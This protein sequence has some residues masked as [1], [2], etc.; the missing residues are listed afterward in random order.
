[1]VSRKLDNIKTIDITKGELYPILAALN[2]GV[3]I[4][5]AAG[6]I[7]FY[8]PVHAEMDGLSSHG[9]IG[10]KV[11]E[12]YDLDENSSLVMRCLRTGRPIVECPVIYKTHRG[13]IVDSINNVYPL[14]KQGKV[15]GVISF[16]KDYNR[17]EDPAD[18]GDGKTFRHIFSGDTDFSLDDIIGSNVSLLEAVTRARMAA[19]TDS[20]VLIYGE[21][22]TGKELFAQAIHNLSARKNARYI[23]VNCAAIP[24]TLLEGILFG[25]SKGA[26]TG[27]LDKPGLFERANGGTLFLDEIN[28]MSREMQPKLLRAIQEK[29]VCRIG[30]HRESK[31]ELKII[32]ST[33]TTPEQAMEAGK[34]RRD[35]LYRLSVV[36]ISLP[37]LRSRRDDVPLLTKHFIEKYNALFHKRVAGVSRKVKRIFDEY[38]WPGNVRELENVIE[39]ALNMVGQDKLIET[40]HLTSGFCLLDIES[41]AIYK[42]SVRLKRKHAAIPIGVDA[43]DRSLSSLILPEGTGDDGE[44]EKLEIEAALSDAD[45]NITDAAAIMGISRQT[46]YRRMKALNIKKAKM[47]DS[48]Q[49]QQIVSQLERYG[50]NIT[51]AARALGVSRQLLTYRMK[52]M[53]IERH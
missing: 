46:F 35:L 34:V 48:K 18:S 10:H 14:S 24:E 39:G 4:T 37:P 23:A 11:T 3:L 32:S 25:T 7:V 5:N 2:I 26:F 15:T 49:H 42:D 47:S 50:W 22:G 12:V 27:A 52:K 40:W 44:A 31:L 29:R 6:E 8:N 20:P 45:G 51:H 16:V 19:R 17:M 38:D 13:Q 1:L 36:Y 21:T 9:V 28:S 33:N 43:T 41:D 53:G 30:S